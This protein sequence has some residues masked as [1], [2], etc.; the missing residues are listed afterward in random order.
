[1][2]DE[3]LPDLVPIES[4]ESSSRREPSVMPQSAR[5]LTRAG[6]AAA[7]AAAL[8]ISGAGAASAQD[9]DAY[10]EPTV[11]A[12]VDGNNIITTITDNG[13]GD[14][15][16]EEVICMNLGLPALDAL[17]LAGLDPEDISM[18]EVMDSVMWIELNN[19]TTV[20]NPEVVVDAVEARS[21]FD[22]PAL[23][24]G[25][26]ASVG[27][28]VS[29]DLSGDLPDLVLESMAYEA[30]VFVPRGIGSV[31]QALDLGS[32]AIELEDGFSMLLNFGS[33]MVGS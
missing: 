8:A 26:Y 1:M 9:N 17:P 29:V 18:A 10:P 4:G 27:A 24:S 32:S 11:S 22:D 12:Q 25:V 15:N 21:L 5:H 23:P 33:E 30:P 31:G 3:R 20:D 7:A 6:L 19:T 2:A 14:H 13:G 16:G 28:C